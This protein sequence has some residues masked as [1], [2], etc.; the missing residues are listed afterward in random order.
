MGRACRSRVAS[1]GSSAAPRSVPAAAAAPPPWRRCVAGREVPPSLAVARRPR[2]E[3]R[4]RVAVRVPASRRDC[5]VAASRCVCPGCPAARSPAPAVGAPSSAGT[6]PR[7]PSTS[8]RSLAALSSSGRGRWPSASPPLGRAVRRA[9]AGLGFAVPPPLSPCPPRA[10]ARRVSPRART[11]VLTLSLRSLARFLPR[12]AH[13][14]PVSEERP[15]RGG[16]L[17]SGSPRSPTWLILPV[18]YA[19]LKD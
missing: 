5:R 12:S 18:A 3:G 17:S 1:R 11:H 10:L 9:V 19:C 14:R 16:A 6:G 2:S 13:V 8:P 4:G 15:R 7:A